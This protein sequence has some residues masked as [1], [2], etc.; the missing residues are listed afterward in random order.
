[1]T[2][3]A[4]GG[5]ASVAAGGPAVAA[6]TAVGVATGVVVAAGLVVTVK[7]AVALGVPAGPDAAIPEQPAPTNPTTRKVATVRLTELAGSGSPGH[8]SR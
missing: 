3:S 4:W 2:I 1:M 8:C 6:G 7:T 5:G